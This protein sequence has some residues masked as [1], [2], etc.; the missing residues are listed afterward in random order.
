MSLPFGAG[1]W[2]PFETATERAILSAWIVASSQ[3]PARELEAVMV[4]APD[5]VLRR[6]GE[7][8]AL[9]RGEAPAAIDGYDWSR[10]RI[11]AFV[12]GIS[13]G[14]AHEASI[15]TPAGPGSILASWPAEDGTYW[16]AW[17]RHPHRHDLWRELEPQVEEADPP[18]ATGAPPSPESP[19]PSGPSSTATSSP[20]AGSTSGP[21]PIAPAGPPA[22]APAAPSPGASSGGAAAGGAAPPAESSAHD[23]RAGAE[24]AA[25]PVRS[26][27][28]TGGVPCVVCKLPLGPL[29]IGR[30]DGAR[31]SHF[32]CARPGFPLSVSAVWG[33]TQGNRLKLLRK[34]Q[35]YTQ[36]RLVSLFGSAGRVSAVELGKKAATPGELV[37][38]ANFYGVTLDVVI[39][40]ALPP[41]GMGPGF[42]PPAPN[43]LDLTPRAP[44]ESQAAEEPEGDPDADVGAETA[45]WVE[46]LAA[47]GEEVGEDAWH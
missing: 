20:S 25:A 32:A 24:L 30:S 22:P 29:E 10:D 18:P 41:T 27:P 14:R 34:G 21:P 19:A 9:V 5:V 39:G 46:E 23:L 35:G 38:C 13:E 44:V 26:A 2:S 11:D 37:A 3:G 33:D 40:R 43:A 42:P 12:A 31:W 16:R 45:A 15:T 28:P 7:L 8:G 47:A 4:V 36:D 1:P 6:R 17:E